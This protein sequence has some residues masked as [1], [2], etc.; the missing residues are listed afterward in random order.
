MV[1]NAFLVGVW[2]VTGR[3]YFWPG[4]VLAGW[5]VALRLDAWNALYRRP[6]TESDIDRELRG[7]R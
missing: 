1:V 3:G 6:I 4:W 5:G 7:G 2:A